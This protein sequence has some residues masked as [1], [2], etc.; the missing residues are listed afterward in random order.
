MAFAGL[1]RRRDRWRRKRPRMTSPL[2]TPREAG[3]TGGNGA[4]TQPTLGTVVRRHREALGL[5]LEDV[6]AAIGGTPSTGFLAQLEDGTVGPAPTLLL[7]LATVLGLPAD[8]VLNAG[9]FATEPQRL[10]ALL[11]LGD[12]PG[13]AGE[14]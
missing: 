13:G 7:K 4:A 8:L 1:H 3:S 10:A 5:S 9:G 2:G 11:E 14:G 6:Q 12:E